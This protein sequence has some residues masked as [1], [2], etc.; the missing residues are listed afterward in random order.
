MV[1][2]L[3]S[4]YAHI[5]ETNQFEHH[6]NHNANTYELTLF[7]HDKQLWQIYQIENAIFRNYHNSSFTGNGYFRWL[8]F[9]VQYSIPTE[10]KSGSSPL[11]LADLPN[12]AEMLI[13]K[14]S[15][16]LYVIF[17]KERKINYEHSQI[18]VNCYNVYVNVRPAGSRTSFTFI[19]TYWLSSWVKCFCQSPTDP[20]RMKGATCNDT[21]KLLCELVIC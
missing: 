3:I 7:F 16:G 1:G 8:T 9:A 19:S 21:V 15:N 20:L 6:T 13:V 14:N 12:L 5:Y 10:P 18:Y 4:S 11:D 2:H 17:G